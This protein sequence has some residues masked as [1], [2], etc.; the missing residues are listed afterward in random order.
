MEIK[1][2]VCDLDKTLLRTDKTFS[3]YTLYVLAKC[4]RDG[5]LLAFATARPKTSVKPFVDAVQP[6]IVITDSGALA[7]MGADV[8][9]RAVLPK[10]TVN[11][12]LHILHKGGH[13]GFITASTDDALLVNRHVDLSEEGW[14]DYQPVFTDFSSGFDR[15]I[16]KITPEILDSRLIDEIKALPDISYIPYH[17]EDWCTITSEDV[18]KWLAVQKIAE[19]LGI[20]AKHI[21]AFGDDF[22]DIEMLEG[23]GVGVAVDNAI[24]EVKAAADF[25]CGTNDNDGVAKWLEE[26]LC[27]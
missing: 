5:I 16:Y 8:V 9:Y 19:H 18:T 1:L 22:G 6:D 14:A 10:E 27:L 4:R 17:G 23:C 11:K 25:I 13:S 12:I 24:D 15:D 21:A 20:D 7:V 2:I 3:P 26:N